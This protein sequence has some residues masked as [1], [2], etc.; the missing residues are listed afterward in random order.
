MKTVKLLSL[1]A[2]VATLSTVALNAGAADEV[3][4][5]NQSTTST[6]TADQQNSTSQYV[7]DATITTKVKTSLLADKDTSGTAIKVETANG[8]VQL[9]GNVKSAE[10]KSRAVDLARQ[11]EGV[12]DVKD[13]IQVN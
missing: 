13:M 9:S 11:I 12:K 4:A 10:E 7:D 2:A 6:T 1:V 8:T 3:A 5:S